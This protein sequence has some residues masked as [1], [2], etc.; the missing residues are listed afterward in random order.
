MDDFL[1]Q[2]IQEKNNLS[3]EDFLEKIK[4]PAT[5]MIPGNMNQANLNQIRNPAMIP[6]GM[7]VIQGQGVQLP[8]IPQENVGNIKPGN[9]PNI[10]NM[11]NLGNFSNMPA[12][13]GATMGMNMF[14]RF[15]PPAMNMNPMMLQQQQ[16]LMKNPMFMQW[17]RPQLMQNMMRMNM[18]GKNFNPN[19]QAINQQQINMNM[20]NMNMMGMNA[21]QIPPQSNNLNLSLIKPRNQWEMKSM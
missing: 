5:A 4:I 14:P 21:N 11:P 15:I 19:N 7:P 10:C 3:L 20:M 8:N 16:M 12:G 2:H 9:I 6:K 17:M 13:Q 1:K 18:M